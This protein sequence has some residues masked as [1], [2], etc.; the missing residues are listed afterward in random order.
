MPKEVT[1]KTFK[2]LSIF[3]LSVAPL[4]A[5]ASAEENKDDI[6]AC[7]QTLRISGQTQ[8][9]V[10]ERQFCIGSLLISTRFVKGG[11]CSE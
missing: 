9:N 2:I 8:C 5:T 6:G 7:Y 4:G 10:V 11:D 3:A 1:M